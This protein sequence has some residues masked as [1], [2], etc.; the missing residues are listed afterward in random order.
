[1]VATGGFQPFLGACIPGLGFKPF[2]RW[3]TMVICSKVLSMKKI[4]KPIRQYQLLILNWFREKTIS[5]GVVNGLNNKTK[6]LA[7]KSYGCKNVSLE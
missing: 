1:M 2:A 5:N 6:V 3:V 4:A 7:I